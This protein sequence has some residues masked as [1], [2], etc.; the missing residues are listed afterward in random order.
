M[1]SFVYLIDLNNDSIENEEEPN[2]TCNN[3]I[4][5]MKYKDNNQRIETIHCLDDIQTQILLIW[6]SFSYN[7]KHHSYSVFHSV[8]K[9]F[10]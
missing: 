4:D 9:F 8:N 3:P 6:D 2:L 5:C 10:S 7:F 1:L